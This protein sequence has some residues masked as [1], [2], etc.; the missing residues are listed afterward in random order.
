MN[1]A[2]LL[3]RRAHLATLAGASATLATVHAEQALAH[4]KNGRADG[5][6]VNE[7]NRAMDALKHAIKRAEASRRRFLRKR[8]RLEQVDG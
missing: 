8:D 2:E 1:S 5:A 6:V 7:L 4:A 3:Q